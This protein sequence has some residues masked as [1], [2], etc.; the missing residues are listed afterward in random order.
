MCVCVCGVCA[1][2][3]AAIY[4]E[5]EKYN[6]LQLTKTG[7]LVAFEIAQKELDRMESAINGRVDSSSCSSSS[8]DSEVEE[9]SEALK[10]LRS[11]QQ[12]DKHFSN[13]ASLAAQ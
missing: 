2:S 11:R 6:T 8:E 9:Q 12:S 1:V 3:P 13:S 5:V 10:R 7:E 4:G